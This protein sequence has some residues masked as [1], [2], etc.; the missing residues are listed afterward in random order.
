M[1]ND[2]E[3]RG[4][5][6]R[7]CDRSFLLMII[8]Q[9]LLSTFI[10]GQFLRLNFLAR[11]ILS[12]GKPLKAYQSLLISFAWRS[13]F[14]S[15][16]ILESD[17]KM[18]WLIQVRIIHLNLL[19]RLVFKNP[20]Q[21]AVERPFFWIRVFLSTKNTWINVMLQYHWISRNVRS[22][23]FIFSNMSFEFS[24]FTISVFVDDIFKTLIL[25]GDF[26]LTFE[27]E[28]GK[29]YIPRQAITTNTVF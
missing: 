29:Q 16:A 4:F 14:A 26:H 23:A 27:V 18:K 24:K 19:W 5:Q 11:S 9:S 22:H 17:L 7:S 20:N 28:L 8:S 1:D 2:R 21:C 3:M 12:F 15:I 13:A 6:S 25:L 10:L